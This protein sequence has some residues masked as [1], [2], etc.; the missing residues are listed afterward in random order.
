[1][2]GSTPGCSHRG[3]R[4]ASAP[5][6]MARKLDTTELSRYSSS[7]AD[8]EPRAA[9]GRVPPVVMLLEPWGAETGEECG[10][11]FGGQTSTET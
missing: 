3:P 5:D 9:E 7:F 2:D 11:N 10:A 6:P 8:S 1:M 4:A